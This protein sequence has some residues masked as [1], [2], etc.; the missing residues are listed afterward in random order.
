MIIK[1]FELTKINLIQKKFLLLFG[2]NDGLKNNEVKK[3]KNKYN[4]PVSKYEENEI[5]ENIENFINEILNKSFFND[6]KIIIISRAT[7][8]IIKL[9]EILLEKNIEETI[10]II[11]ADSLEKKSK[12]RTF[13]EKNNELIATAFYPDTNETLSK[14]AYNFFKEKN[15]SIA[16]SNINFLVSRCNGQR[17]V[18]I[19]ELEKIHLFSI[20]NKITDVNIIKLSNLS[21][22]F[23]ISEI[24]DN[25][26]I[27]NKKKTSTMINENNFSADESIIF[28]RILLQKAKKLLN[29]STIYEK[30]NDLE[31]TIS[32]A[33]PPIFWKEK[34][35]IK[36]QL[37]LWNPQKIKSLIFNIN[38][39]ELEIKKNINSSIIILINFILE[40][41]SSDVNN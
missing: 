21:E 22:N 17:E 35:I 11:K 20:N 32:N 28:T 14:I 34:E 8:K 2:E 33:K 24:I 10:I 13:F 5:L 4:F 9:V 23:K 6:Q 40:I 27:K 41:S 18:L 29:L 3:I 7:D 37:K 12:L 39:I 30:N 16:Q 31:Q 36:G 1:S 26:L 15:I 38:K 25:C 19:K